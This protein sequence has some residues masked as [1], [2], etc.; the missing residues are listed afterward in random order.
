MTTSIMKEGEDPVG[1]YYMRQ[2][3]ELVDMF[4]EKRFFD[5]SIE[6]CD[7]RVVEEYIGWMLEQQCKSAIKVD[8]LRRKFKNT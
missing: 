8:R 4:F 5:N 3:Q 6:R 1:K 7:M 2:A